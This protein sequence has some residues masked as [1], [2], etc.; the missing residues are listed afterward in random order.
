MDLQSQV[1]IGDF[2]IWLDLSLFP[3]LLL[4]SAAS[5]QESE[6]MWLVLQGEGGGGREQGRDYFLPVKQLIYL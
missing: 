1:A 6:E 2:P 3:C 4:G 5:G